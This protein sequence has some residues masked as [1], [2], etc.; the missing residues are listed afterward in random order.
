MTARGHI[1]DLH[2]LATIH[3]V[4][5]AYY[6]AHGE[7]QT[8][9]PDS[10]LAI[11]QSLAVSI[12]SIEDAPDVLCREEQHIWKT[13]VEP[14]TVDWVGSPSSLELRLPIDNQDQT[15][16]CR[17][18]LEDGL[19]RDWDFDF[20]QTPAEMLAEIGG[21]RYA[22]KKMP[23]PDGLPWGY[24]HLTL[25]FDDAES[26]TM[27]VSAPRHA[28][29]GGRGTRHRSWGAFLPLYAVQTADGLGTGN[30]G[31]LATLVSWVREMGG[32]MFGTLPLLATFLSE[33]FEPSPY[34]PVSR[35]FWSEFYLDFRQ[36]PEL[37]ASPTAKAMLV[38]SDMAREIEELR[39]DE[40]V[41]YQHVMTVKRKILME[42]SQTLLS[43]PTDRRAQFHEWV[44]NNPLAREYAEFMAVIDRTGTTWQKWPQRQRDG[45]IRAGDFDS[46]DAHYHLYVQWLAQQQLAAI[47][48][49]SGADGSGLYL[50]LPLGVHEGGFDVWS[51]R[52]SFAVDARVGAPP[53][54]L[55]T[56]GQDWGFPPMHPRRS[57]EHGYDYFIQSM[58]H[59][60]R[61]AGALRVDHVMGL[62]R[63]YWIPG[64]ASPRDGVYVRYNAEELYAILILESHR[65]QALVIGEDLGTVPREVNAAMSRHRLQRMYV[66]PFQLGAEDGTALNAVGSELLAS[67]NTHDLAPFA[68]E[69]STIEVERQERITRFLHER[70][71]LDTPTTEDPQMVMNALT[72]FM[73]DSPARMVLVNLEDLWLETEQQNVPGT[74]DEHPNWRRKARYD[75]EAFT[76]MP[77]VTDALRELDLLRKRGR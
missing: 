7:R 6:D 41:H 56:G 66:F 30:Y 20:S 15:V 55:N 45:E 48:E 67:L 61:F 10:L 44:G 62:H 31:D 21:A 28:Y 57:R 69:W 73:A 39:R 19:S 37:D 26:Q 53:D 17:L 38:S 58:R 4:Q 63:L 13:R 43:E 54:I 52:D 12:E 11:L 71:W 68:K 36:I 23:L 18:K 50:D 3:G 14:V 72:R 9:A 24:H 1:R 47:S 34:S 29:T 40:L 64:D 65:A 2:R 27:V 59:H 25:T 42:L 32:D 35:R 70:G 5:L 74:T 8:A 76:R 33:P 22:V 60:L 75:L 16:T 49:R 46:D 77:K 51:E